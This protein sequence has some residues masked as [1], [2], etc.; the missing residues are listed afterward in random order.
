VERQVSALRPH[1]TGR[2]SRGVRWFKWVSPCPE[3]EALWLYVTARE[4]TLSCKVAHKH[5]EQHQY[6]SNRLTSLL[7]KR[8]VA[9]EATRE[10]ACFLRGEV[11]VVEE[12]DSKGNL[13]SSMWCK[14][15]QLPEALAQSKQVFGDSKVHR[16]WVWSG[17]AQY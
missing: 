9:S 8:R 13:S 16:A 14:K 4:V 6:R 3:I 15:A 1:E 12:Y 7:A 11:A 2:S 17:P 10:A 5:F